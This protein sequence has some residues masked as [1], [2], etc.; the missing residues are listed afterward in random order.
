MDVIIPPQNTDDSTQNIVSKKKSIGIFLVT[1]WVDQDLKQ[2]FNILQ[3]PSF[4]IE[5]VK[6]VLYNILCAVHFLQTAN[7]VHRDL[8]PGNILLTDNCGVRICDFGLARTMPK[9]IDQM[10]GIN[11]NTME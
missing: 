2:L 9:G 7:I 6:T 11:N 5:H 3:P 1:T 4:D 8:K 10:I